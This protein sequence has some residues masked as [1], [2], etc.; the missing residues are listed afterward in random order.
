MAILKCVWMARLTRCRS[1]GAGHTVNLQLAVTPAIAARVKTPFGRIRR[2]A[3][4]AGIEFITPDRNSPSLSTSAVDE[5]WCEHR[6]HQQSPH[7]NDSPPLS[8]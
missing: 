4:N 2:R 1:S 3:G 7:D 6:D 5:H 8:K